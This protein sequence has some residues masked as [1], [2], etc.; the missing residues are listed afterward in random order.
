MKNGL[1]WNYRPLRT[2]DLVISWLYWNRDMLLIAVERHWRNIAGEH[3][4][5]CQR[6]AEGAGTAGPS[7][8]RPP[9]GQG[10]FKTRATP[11]L[12]LPN[13][14]NP[15]RPPG[16]SASSK[17]RFLFAG[18]AGGILLSVFAFGGRVGC[19]FSHLRKLNFLRLYVLYLCW[20]SHRPFVSNKTAD[21]C[22]S[23]KASIFFTV[24][25]AIYTVF[26]LRGLYLV[27]L[28]LPSW[29]IVLS[30]RLT[31]HSGKL[32]LLF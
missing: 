6:C 15:G 17:S 27:G 32:Y 9:L 20:L 5:P 28:A 23:G 13:G 12:P 2:Q 21:L 19:Q 25:G 30:G 24:S 29:P 31:F 14:R 18:L 16:F 7:W 26:C 10:A 1:H 22:F 11:S 4:N 8:I 3:G